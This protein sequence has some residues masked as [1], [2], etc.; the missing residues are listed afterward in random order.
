[1]RAMHPIE[2]SNLYLQ[3]TSK[4]EPTSYWPTGQLT[5]LRINK[6]KPGWLNFGVSSPGNCY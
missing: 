1:M 6:P 5:Y 3:A 2:I 4:A